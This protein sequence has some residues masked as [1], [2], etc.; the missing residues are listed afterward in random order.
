MVADVLY[1]SIIHSTISILTPG[2][3]VDKRGKKNIARL[4]NNFT[5]MGTKGVRESPFYITL[6]L[7]IVVVSVYCGSPTFLHT[8]PIVAATSTR[9]GRMEVKIGNLISE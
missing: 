5:I 6:L 9:M 1:Q 3:N 8:L 2:K 4:C 7:I